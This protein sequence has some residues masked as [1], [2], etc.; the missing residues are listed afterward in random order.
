MRISLNEHRIAPPLL[1]T[2]SAVCTC[3]RMCTCPSNNPQRKNRIP[4]HQTSKRPCPC[5]RR[6]DPMSSSS[7]RQYPHASSTLHFAPSHG[8]RSCGRSGQRCR[9]KER[10]GSQGSRDH[11]YHCNRLRLV[12]ASQTHKARSSSE[13]TPPNPPPSDGYSPLRTTAL[14]FLQER[15]D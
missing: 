15:G 4:P 10:H 7:R 11:R 2:R 14:R 5:I 9:R 8:R 13:R 6:R 3:D 1:A 12:S